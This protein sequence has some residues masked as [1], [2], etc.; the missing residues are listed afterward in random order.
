MRKIRVNLHYLHNHYKNKIQML[1]LTLGITSRID[2]IN[3]VYQE[4]LPELSFA[5]LPKAIQRRYTN[6]VLYLQGT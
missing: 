1:E 2:E 6:C 3:T 5:P 4:E